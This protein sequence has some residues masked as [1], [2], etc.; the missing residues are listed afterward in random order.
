MAISISESAARKIG[1]FIAADGRP[2]V[3]FRLSVEGGGCKGFSYDL[4][5]D[6][7]SGEDDTLIEIGGGVP[8][9]A[10]DGVSRVLLDGAQIDWKS[11]LVEEKFSISNPNASSSC[12]CGTS[13]SV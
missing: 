3:F 7:A 13:F 1:E 12:G 5:L 8:A 2:G 4:G 11:S 10:V 9:V 6:V